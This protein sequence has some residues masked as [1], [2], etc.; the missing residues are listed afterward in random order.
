MKTNS[1]KL[2]IPILIL[3]EIILTLFLIISYS[4][5]EPYNISFQDQELLLNI[6]GQEIQNGFY[7]DESMGKDALIQTPVFTLPKGIYQVSIDY[8]IIHQKGQLAVIEI[9]Y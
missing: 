4:K 6:P 3:L 5:K 8:K 1:N 9:M 7:C 2:F